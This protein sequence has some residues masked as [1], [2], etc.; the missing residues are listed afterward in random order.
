M[1]VLC[2][3][4]KWKSF[5]IGMCCWAEETATEKS[6][7]DDDEKWCNNIPYAL[8][9]SSEMFTLIS[10][11]WTLSYKYAPDDK[12]YRRN[13]ITTS[14]TQLNCYENEQCVVHE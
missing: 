4:A 13:E 5:G 7:K 10:F 12:V 3:C 9:F 8:R 6:L 14:S 2:A 11:T 1:H